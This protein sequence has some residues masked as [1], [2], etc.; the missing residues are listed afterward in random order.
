MTAY[1]NLNKNDILKE[2]LVNISKMILDNQS[3]R[4]LNDQ[5]ISL[6]HNEPQIPPM[7]VQKQPLEIFL[8][9]SQI[10]RENTCVGVSLRPATY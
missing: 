2:L 10:L 1:F 9:I 7:F 8:K 3:R 6:P 4:V 5:K